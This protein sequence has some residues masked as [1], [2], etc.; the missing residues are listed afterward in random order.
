MSSREEENVLTGENTGDCIK[1][2][3]EETTVQIVDERMFEKKD[4]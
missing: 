2:M 1:N 4:T 3:N